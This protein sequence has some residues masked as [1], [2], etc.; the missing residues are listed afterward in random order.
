MVFYYDGISY[1][2]RPCICTGAAV[3][4]DHSYS[5][6]FMQFPWETNI[7]RCFRVDEAYLWE[8]LHSSWLGPIQSL[9]IDEGRC[10]RRLENGIY[11]IVDWKSVGSGVILVGCRWPFFIPSTPPVELPRSE[12]GLSGHG[13]RMG[14]RKPLGS[15]PGV[16]S[17]VFAVRPYTIDKIESRLV[18]GRTEQVTPFTPISFH[19]AN[20][21]MTLA[22]K[23]PPHTTSPKTSPPTAHSPPVPSS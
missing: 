23:A 4:K 1:S 11:T 10:Y 14:F 22:S 6:P 16:Y 12:S 20:K 15:H 8:I 3:H 21:F 9:V 13:V 19:L 2:K 7:L 5:Y 18:V 17:P